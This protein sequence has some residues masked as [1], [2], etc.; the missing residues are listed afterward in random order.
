[1]IKDP[2]PS[3]FAY[4]LLRAVSKE[5]RLTRCD[6]TLSLLLQ[7]RFTVCRGVHVTQ[8]PASD[9]K[10]ASE[11]LRTISRCSN[12]HS[13]LLLSLRKFLVQLC[14]NCFSQLA[15]RH[16]RGTDIS[17]RIQKD[18]RIRSVRRLGGRTRDI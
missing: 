4:A 15:L 10:L 8:L 6:A 17:R 14:Q 3:N 1:M 5:H 7:R 13:P 18:A 2:V 11:A 12:D 9:L 16:S